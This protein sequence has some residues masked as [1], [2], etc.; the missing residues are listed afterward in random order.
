M[1][2]ITPAVPLAG[3]KRLEL[4]AVEPYG[5]SKV[6]PQ[7]PIDRSIT[8]GIYSTLRA[9]FTIERIEMEL[10]TGDSE[11]VTNLLLSN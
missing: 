3:G 9:H 7:V 11:L 8:P 5:Q 10:F 2:E 4:P 1:L 6:E